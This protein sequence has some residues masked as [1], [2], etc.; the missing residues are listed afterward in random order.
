MPNGVVTTPVEATIWRMAW[1]AHVGDVDVAAV[2]GDR[3]RRVEAR[4]GAGTV[5]EGGHARG[6]GERG[7]DAARNHDLADDVVVRVGDVEVAGAVA[8]DPVRMIEAR[9]GAGG[10]GRAALAGAAGERGHGA[11]G[12]ATLRMVSLRMSVT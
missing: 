6:A 9:G 8:G 3:V 7:D 5:G 10:V 2:E 11:R 1:L 12:S 4:G